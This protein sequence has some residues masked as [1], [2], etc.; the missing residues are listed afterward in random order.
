MQDEANTPQVQDTMATRTRALVLL[1]MLALYEGLTAVQA[2]CDQRILV[3]RPTVGA[4][5]SSFASSS[6]SS[7]GSK[8]SGQTALSG[9]LL[10]KRGS[11]S[12]K[13]VVKKVQIQAYVPGA[14][15]PIFLD[16]T[17]PQ[18]TAKEVTCTYKTQL[19]YAST[20]GPVAYLKGVV[21]LDDGSQCVSDVLTVDPKAAA[22]A[23]QKAAEAAVA[24]ALANAGNV[25][26]DAIDRANALL[27]ESGL[28]PINLSG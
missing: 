4:A 22:E 7:A 10:L 27:A 20:D 17:C 3:A 12:G 26:S 5:S 16:A 19:Q 21:T 15:E 28:P 1:A 24:E 18:G 25:Q 13:A 8:T 14:K 23:A 9:G 2:A 6:S 11:G